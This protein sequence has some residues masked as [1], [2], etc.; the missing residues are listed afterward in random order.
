MREISDFEKIEIF[1]KKMHTYCVSSLS[2]DLGLII[3]CECLKVTEIFSKVE[4]P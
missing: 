1:F 4:N 3:I 2:Y